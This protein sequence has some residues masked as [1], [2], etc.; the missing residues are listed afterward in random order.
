MP[1]VVESLVDSL[2]AGVARVT[3]LDKNVILAHWYAEQGKGGRLSVEDWPG[4]NPAGIRPGNPNVDALAVGV[5][6]EGF[7]IFPTPVAGAQA[8]SLL[9]T[10]D[11]NYSG[12]RAAA[13]K[14]PITQ[15]RA[16]ISSPWDSGHYTNQTTGDKLLAAYEAV[17]GAQ[18][19]AGGDPFHQDALAAEAT[20]QSIFSDMFG[21]IEKP[22]R[23][24]LMGLAGIAAFAVGVVILWKE[25]GSEKGGGGGND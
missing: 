25:Q 17:T 16:I 24:V 5:S 23:R 9:L 1:V 13:G 6:P 2:A 3:G 14:D 22:V 20:R 10:K 7:D 4:N 15:L 21:W 12:V 18:V 8:Y 19:S 11:P